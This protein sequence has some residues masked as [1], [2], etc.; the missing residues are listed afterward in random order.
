MWSPAYTTRWE[1]MP[2]VGEESNTSSREAVDKPL[3]A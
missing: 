3:K 1:E 2:V